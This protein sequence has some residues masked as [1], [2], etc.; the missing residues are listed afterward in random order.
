MYAINQI[1]AEELTVS[2]TEVPLT[3][4]SGKTSNRVL[5]RVGGAPIR[6]RADGTAPT[7]TTGMYVAA[8]G[9]IDWTDSV[10]NH[11]GLITNVQFIRDTS[12]G[13]DAT[14]SVAYFD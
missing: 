2:T 13:G 5:I 4:V 11:R 12:A 9:Y 3:G 7:A 14:L 10:T 6:W 1:G 8:G